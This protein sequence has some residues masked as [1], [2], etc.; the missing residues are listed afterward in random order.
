MWI[1]VFMGVSWVFKVIIWVIM[2]YIGSVS[3]FVEFGGQMSKNVHDVWK[4]FLEMTLCVSACFVEFYVFVIDEIN[5]RGYKLVYYHVF[6]WKRLG[7]HPQGQSK[8]PRGRTQKV[9]Q[10]LSKAAPNDWGNRRLLGQ[11]MGAVGGDIELWENIHILSLLTQRRKDMMVQL[12][13]NGSSTIKRRWG[14]SHAQVHCKLRGELVISLHFQIIGLEIINEYF[15]YFKC[16]YKSLTLR[17]F[18]SSKS[19]TPNPLE[20]P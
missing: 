9:V 16:V 3:I 19:K 2:I 18:Y 12:W 10:R 17:R 14:L 6:Y 20:I 15:S 8:G 7:K 4:C 11:S 1:D 5:L 13:T